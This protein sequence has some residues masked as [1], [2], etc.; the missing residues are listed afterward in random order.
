M[1]V[2]VSLADELVGLDTSD[3]GEEAY[4]VGDLG[5]LAGGAPLGGVILIQP[6]DATATAA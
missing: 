4:H 1:E 3:H 2:R 6:D 5:E